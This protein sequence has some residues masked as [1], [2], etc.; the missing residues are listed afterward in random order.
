MIAKL[1]RLA[2][3]PRELIDRVVQEGANLGM[4]LAPP[5]LTVETPAAALPALPPP[6]LLRQRLRGTAID[7]QIAARAQS[8]TLNN[9]SPIPWRRDA[10]SGRETGLAYFRRIPYLDFARAGDHKIIWELNRHQHLVLLAQDYLL[11]ATPESLSELESQLESWMDANPFQRGINWASALEVAFRS[12]SWIWVEHLAGPRLSPALRRRMLEEL[13]RHGCHLERNLSFYFSPNTHLLGEAVALHALGVFF[14]AWPRSDRWRLEGHRV[15][16]EQLQRQVQSDGSHFEQSSY[17]HVYALDMFLFH[18]LLAGCVRDWSPVLRRMCVYLDA[19]LGRTRRLPYLGDDDG[20][21]FFFPVGPHDEFGR[22]TLATAAAM[23]PEADWNW[24]A[25]DFGSQA[26]WWL[27]SLPESPGGSAAYHSLRFADS[28]VVVLS[29]G[30]VQILFDTGSFGWGA[31]GHSHSDALQVVVRHGAEEI[32]IDPGTFTYVGDPERRDYFRGSSAHN[33]VRIDGQD[34]AA[35]AGP[36]GWKGRPVVTCPVCECAREPQAV[37]GVCEYRGFRH[38]RR[39]VFQRSALE[40]EDV[41]EGPAGD[42]IVEWFWQCG[43][44]RSP[45]LVTPAG[46]EKIDG[47]RSLAMGHQEPSVVLRHVYKGKL[48]AALAWRVEL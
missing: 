36:F 48:P 29:R 38:R 24:S 5:R 34:Q 1:L 33:T 9:R 35:P 16:A 43:A 41:I 12:M 8:M 39:I 27:P 25:A 19:L 37:E 18:V 23:L 40:V 31:A 2:G 47:W 45:R 26:A 14:P 15:V 7:A 11:R 4:L 30:D 44:T 6:D 21:R 22:A 28:G 3:R 17:Y 13:F 32:L 42:H 20:G 46:T 10:V